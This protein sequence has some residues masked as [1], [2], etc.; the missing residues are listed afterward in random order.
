V[1]VQRAVHVGGNFNNGGNVSPFYWNGN[2]GPGNTNI[3]IGGRSDI[4][5]IDE[6][7]VT[8]L[9]KGEMTR[10]AAWLVVGII[11]TS[12]S[13]KDNTAMK[14]WKNVNFDTMFTVEQA[15]TAAWLASEGKR[16]RA[17]VKAYLENENLRI[18]LICDIMSGAYR[19]GRIRK[20]TFYD[21]KS[22]KNRTIVMPPFRDQ[23]VHWMIMLQLRPYMEP[24]FIHHT[25]ASLDNRGQKLANLTIKHWATCHKT[26]TRWVV[27]MDIHHYYESIDQDIL[28]SMLSKRIRDRR[29]MFI[30]EKIIKQHD[31]G[32]PLGYYLSQWLANFYLSDMDHY[33][34]EKLGI[35]CYMRYVD[36]IIICT[37]TKEQAL[38]VVDDVR[39]YLAT[40]KLRVKLSGEGALRTYRWNQPVDYVGIRTYRDGFQELRKERYLATRRTL[41][42]I[43]KKDC[44]SLSQARSIMARKGYIKHT[45]STNLKREISEIV[46]MYSVRRVI[47]NHD[48]RNAA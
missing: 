16:G 18:D 7:A 45:G 13:V 20:R 38:R 31:K 42:S 48:K 46:H 5:C 40:R 3:N 26:D 24:M 28:L 9:P 36:D 15:E 32:L 11:R 2:N 12:W 39:R 4:L 10:K 8:T 21:H 6:R 22:G 23:I 34:K 33:I 47:S 37:R 44:I 17:E 35:K 43:R 27:Q 25:V 29:V 19:M 14:T 1:R 30:L 41:A